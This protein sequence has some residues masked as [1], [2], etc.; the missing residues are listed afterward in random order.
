M[1]A[2]GIRHRHD[3][4]CILC[5]IDNFTASN[6]THGT[7]AGDRA[8]AA[9]ADTCRASLR[10]SDLLARVGGDEFALLLPHT[11]LASALK[12]AEKLRLAIADQ[13]ATEPQ[14]PPL[15]ASFGLATLDRGTPDLE[16]LL[17][18]AR[19]A[20]HEAKAAGRNRC[21][22]WLP[23]ATMAQNLR[24]RVFKAG[25][26]AFNGGRS[27]IDCTVRSLSDAGA[28]FDVTSSAGIPGEFKLQIEADGLSRSCRVVGKKDRH[29][30]VEFT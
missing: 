20:L 10:T 6:E 3:V 7:L 22:E 30:E 23:A 29:L 17:D 19:S 4:S 16:T 14:L 15:T 25:K 24:R 1:T 9:T 11:G 5:N 27:A 28:S 26:I 18:H 12:V 8:L 21:A 2:L 13:S